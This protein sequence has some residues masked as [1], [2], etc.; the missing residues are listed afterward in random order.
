MRRG[1]CPIKTWLPEKWVKSGSVLSKQNLN[2]RAGQTAWDKTGSVRCGDISQYLVHHLIQRVEEECCLGRR[3]S[4]E[5]VEARGQALGRRA[6][7][8][9]AS[10]DEGRRQRHLNLQPKP[11][12]L[13][14]KAAAPSWS[15]TMSP[16]FEMWPRRFSR[17][18][19]SRPGCLW[20]SRRPGGFQEALV[21]DQGGPVGCDHAWDEYRRYPC[22]TPRP[23]GATSWFF[24]ALS[25]AN[26]KSSVALQARACPALSRSLSRCRHSR[27]ALYGACGKPNDGVHTNPPTTAVRGI[28]GGQL[29]VPRLSSRR[30][31]AP[32]WPRPDRSRPRLG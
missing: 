10:P 26:V 31:R 16:A 12:K 20:R 19:D 22:G 14:P 5:R 17:N 9:F 30:L 4:S 13:L 29:R 27:P 8:L 15:L 7:L 24:Y 32:G 23:F 2:P 3:G 25:I 11:H 1:Q 6:E 18:R 21:G 28:V